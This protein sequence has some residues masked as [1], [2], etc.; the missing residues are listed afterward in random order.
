MSTTNLSTTAHEMGHCL[1][2]YHTFQGGDENVA[3]SGNCANCT[4]T[5]DGLCD[6]EADPHSDSYDTG[7]VIDTITC[8][9]F[10][11]VD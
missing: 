5:G 3:R 7:N 9:Y 8:N 2:L 10:G 11:L 6:T 4:T 1:G